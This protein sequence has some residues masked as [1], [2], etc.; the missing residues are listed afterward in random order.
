MIS[1]T[2]LSV[3]SEITC[4]DAAET[5]ITNSATSQYGSRMFEK[6]MGL[7]DKL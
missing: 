5:G 3:P 2:A 4:D 7:N 6:S 1:K